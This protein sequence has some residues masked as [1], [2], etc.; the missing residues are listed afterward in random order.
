MFWFGGDV[1]CFGVCVCFEPGVSGSVRVL[2]DGH[3]FGSCGYCWVQFHD[4]NFGIQL[5]L[6]DSHAYHILVVNVC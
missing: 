2:A 1:L 4:L 5:G 3:F 6:R